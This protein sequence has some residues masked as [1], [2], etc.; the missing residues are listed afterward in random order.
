MSLSCMLRLPWA[1]WPWWL[2]GVWLGLWLV[3]LARII[4]RKVLQCSKAPLHAW[5]GPGGGLEQPIPLARRIWVPVVNASLWAYAADTPSHLAFWAAL[6]GAGL[7]STLLL[8]ALIDWDTTLLPDWVV[9]PLG[10]AGLASSYAGFTPHSL[11]VSAASAA[12]VLGLLGG[13]AWV[14]QRIKGESGIGSGDLKLLAA[15]ATWWGVLG[16]L[17]VVLWASVLTVF[18]YLVWCLF[19]GFS[20]QAEWPFGPAIV[21]AALVWGFVSSGISG[22]TP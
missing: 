12:V 5:Q 8:L 4:P 18:W 19:K 13:L 7:A 14:F 16:V 10:V 6:P 15:L 1:N 20:R 17:Y 22:W 3:P 2:A 11:L 21:L 9:L